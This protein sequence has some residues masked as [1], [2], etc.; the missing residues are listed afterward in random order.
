VGGRRV[1][2][3]KGVVAGSA[4][5]VG[6]ATELR[7]GDGYAWWDAGAS[8]AAQYWIEDVDLNGKRT[9]HGPFVPVAGAGDGRKIARVYAQPVLLDELNAKAWNKAG[10]F[11]TG[12][13][14]A[15]SEDASRTT[16]EAASRA[17][18][19]GANGGE[20]SASILSP[21]TGELSK[22]SADAAAR[23]WEIA[24]RNAVKIGVKRDGWYR[25][26]QAELVAAGLDGNAD[27]RFLQ[28]FADGQQVP[29]RVRDA[30]GALAPD[31]FIEFYGR[32]L[33]T[34]TTDT[35]T[36]YLVVGAEPGSKLAKAQKLGTAI[37][38]EAA[39]EA[40]LAGDPP[41]DPDA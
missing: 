28:L 13:P 22:S 31:S 16:D 20:V 3:N 32:G 41:P 26:T 30:Q 15:A 8:A 5:K 23:Q 10:V 21:R 38:D 9:L 7:A 1:R 11:E 33:D 6:A 24:G 40:L 14:A 36:Y 37:L 25:V 35:R 29:I 4:L 12:Y 19:E 2:V 39:F 27:P 34:P 18:V 17:Q